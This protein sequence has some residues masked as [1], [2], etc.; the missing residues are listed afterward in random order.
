MNQLATD[1]GKRSGPMQID[2]PRGSE[3]DWARLWQGFAGRRKVFFSVAAGTF[4]LILAYTFLMP[5]S[6]TTSVKV[7]AGGS[8]ASQSGNE[9]NSTLPLLNALLAA[10][11]M[12]TTETYAELFQEG[13][14]AQKV[15]DDLH[16]NMS[17]GQLMNAV[18]VKPIVQTNLLD[19]SVTW[20]TAQGSA[21]VA[22]AFAGAFVDR[23]RQLVIGQADSALATLD[24]QLP[25][26]EHRAV[27]AETALAQFQARNHLAD[28]QTQTQ[29]T[30][31]AASQIDAKIGAAAVDQRQAQ[32][33]LT[34]DTAQ[35]ATVSPTISGDTSVAPNPV[36][37]A[38][39]S[40][41]A[42]VM[43][44]LQTAQQQYTEKHPTVVGLEHQVSEIRQQIASTPATVVS[45]TNTI[46]NPVYQQIS[47]QA[48]TL[49]AQ[50]AADSAQQKE[51]TKQHNDMAPQIA[52]LPAE[53]TRLLQLQRDA[54]M[55]DDVLAA[56]QQKRSEA[57]ITKTTA[58]SDVTIT[59]PASAADAQVR[60]NTML[61][62]IVGLFSSIVLGVVATLVFQIFDRK[63][64]N[65]RQIED[66][67]NLPVLASVPQLA[68]LRHRLDDA[69]TPLLALPSGDLTDPAKLPAGDPVARAMAVESFLQLV[70]ALRYST[71]ADKRI[72][73]V[74]ITSPKAGEGKS[75]IALNTAITMAHIQPRVLL[76]D[77]DLR[78][79]SLHAKLNREIGI[80]LSD[81]LVGNARLEDVIIP[82]EHEGLDLLTSGTR[83]PNSVKL[84]Q[85]DMYDEIVEKLLEVYTTIII[86]APALL[87]VIDA[88]ILAAKSDG[89]VMVVSVGDTDA[90]AVRQAMTRLQSVGNPN[91]LGTVA[92]R[93]N[94]SKPD[95][96]SDYFAET[97]HFRQ[98]IA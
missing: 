6:Y 8:G 5:R 93:A 89:T 24:Q 86:D 91:V 20:P 39:Q 14:V 2:A 90:E 40:Q 80:G 97:R 71:T 67:L 92:N 79:P 10:S 55:A 75:T 96:D 9:S 42:Q 76:I 68:D 31:N 38:L 4:I 11:G 78:R 32:A 60:P 28:V 13:P 23:Q 73:S 33:Q 21:D 77:G 19:L 69:Q 43:V 88:A 94:V 53:A 46:P 57:S 66:E 52:A 37:S 44:Q 34:S 30:I 63:L 56:L 17:T 95:A 85:S 16:L 45:A 87:P 81:V 22:N 58:M 48:A 84:L 1:F 82:T 62:I 49:R 59:A 29:N 15:I 72:R 18:K 98:A 74:T 3:F 27:V 7:I 61:N 70:T 36:Y 12:S 26:A 35:L 50:I 25:D 83:T 65:V 41:L 64:R 51:L 54:K 47:Q